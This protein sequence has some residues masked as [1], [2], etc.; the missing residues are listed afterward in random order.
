MRS[1][2]RAGA[3]ALVDMAYHARPDAPE[4]SLRFEAETLKK[5]KMPHAIIMRH[6]TPHFL[7]VFSGEGYSAGYYSYLWSEVLD[8]DAFSAFEET[9][10]V[11]DP[12]LAAKLREH[13]YAAGGSADPEEL[14]I[15]FRGRCRRQTPQRPNGPSPA[16]RSGSSA[17]AECSKG[18]ATLMIASDWD[19]PF[20][21]PFALAK[22]P[23][24]A[25]ATKLGAAHS[26]P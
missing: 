25:P 5:L 23:V 4:E 12:V 1:L 6:R 17:P 16:R 15:A 19:A 9:G 3:S 18:Q 11:F 22:K 14:Y 20:R 24:R 21:P 13:I 8:A 2:R 10:N 26:R 7:H